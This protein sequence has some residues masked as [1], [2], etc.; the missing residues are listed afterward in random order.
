LS[1]RVVT[2]QGRTYVEGGGDIA[3]NAYPFDP[4]PGRVPSRHPLFNNRK[5]WYNQPYRPFLEESADEAID[6]AAVEYS[7]VIDDWAREAGF[8]GH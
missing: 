2:Y 8:T 7:K 4:P 1:I 3:P 5:H 6:R